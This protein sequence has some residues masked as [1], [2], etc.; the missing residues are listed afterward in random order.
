MTLCRNPFYLALLSNYVSERGTVLPANQMELYHS[1][2]DG[3]LKKCAGKLEKENLSE[4]EV[5]Q[6]AKELALF[7]Q[8][9]E[10]CGLECPT[11]FFYQR[12]D[13]VYWRKV[14]SVLKYAKIC[15]LGGQ[16]ET[17]SF[18]HRRFQEFFW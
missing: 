18:V 12:E 6:A 8:R 17:I 14:F 4:S 3:R 2:I 9:T 15:R 16:D 7:M 11:S 10:E 1:F 5:Y 13:E